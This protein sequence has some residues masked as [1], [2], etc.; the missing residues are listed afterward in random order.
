MDFQPILGKATESFLGGDIYYHNNI[1]I[2]D[3]YLN[4]D[5]DTL[6]KLTLLA[7]LYSKKEN[8]SRNQKIVY[9]FKTVT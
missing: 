8:Q 4:T 6:Q 5:V 9:L 2:N 7:Y 3:W 1:N